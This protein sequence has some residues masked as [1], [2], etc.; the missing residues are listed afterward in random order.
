MVIKKTLLNP[1]SEYLILDILQYIKIIFSDLFYI[2]ISFVIDLILLLFVKKS[3][4]KKEKLTVSF[5]A[6]INKVVLDLNRIQN[7]D[8]NEK[9]KK[10]DSLK[11]K[12][13]LFIVLNGFNFLLLRLPL[14]I[15]SFY[16]FI[17]R[18]DNQEKVYKPNLFTYLICR[19]FRFC[20]SLNGFFYFI[21][22]NSFIIQFFILLKLDKNFKHVFNSFKIYLKKLFLTKQMLI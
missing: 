11:N 14:A 12:I 16:G 18:Y 10:K 19:Y 6:N 5:V 17:S 3:I 8:N 15:S 9:Q 13:T 1:K 22:L 7:N 2:F 4:S 21:Y 20:L